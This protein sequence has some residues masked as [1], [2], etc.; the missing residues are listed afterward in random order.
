MAVEI[1]PEPR[2]ENGPPREDG[3][4]QAIVNPPMKRGF[5][6]WAIISALCVTGLLGALENTVVSTSMPTIV[7]ELNIGEN[8][9]WITNA[10]FLT[11]AAVQPL[12]GQLAN[13][14]GRRWLTIFI[15]AV[16]ILGSGICGGANGANMLIVGRAVQ[17]I[18]SGG[19]NMIVDVI[20]SDLVPL[21]ERGN[22]IA[23]VLTV[24]SIGSSMGPFVGGIIVQRTTWRWVFYINLPVGGF[25]LVLLFLFLHTNY[26]RETTFSEKIKRIDYIGNVLI[27][28]ATSAVLCA[29]TYGGSRYAWSSWQIIVPLVLGLA[30]MVIFMVFEQSKFCREPVVPPRLFKNRTSLVVFINTYLFTLL[31]YWVLFFIP[32]YFQAIL[33]SSAARAGVQMLP[34]TLVA[35]PGAVIAVIILSKFGKYKA[36]H[37]AGF[38]ILTLG[39]GLFANLD[40]YSSDAEW[41]IYQIIGALGSG[42]ILNTL[43]PAFQAPLAESDQAAATATWAFMRSFGNVWGVAIPAS[44]FNN[45][46]NTYAYRISDA[47]VREILSNG[48]AYQHAS[49][50]FINSLSEPVKSE[51]IGVFSDS[52]KLV[53]EVSIAFCGLAC[54]LVF[55][56][57]DVPLRKELETDYGMAEKDDIQAK[58]DSIPDAEKAGSD[59]SKT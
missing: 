36:L 32:V 53:W 39:I 51:V 38:I 11:S 59:T 2:E 3:S 17:G 4:E 20:V 37:L 43:L 18:G 6:F 30:G 47:S 1:E 33:G 24:Y 58:K 5:Q 28:G 56:E 22:F 54:I 46:F 21:R 26:E 7:E 57:K 25:A 19:V 27:M 16:F 14:F 13:V 52:L 55:F 48:H 44:I 23:I 45:Q 42:M 41:I 35:I 34:I 10:F 31:L 29:L 9:I 8:Y 15:V 49:N 50:T 12:F 40:R